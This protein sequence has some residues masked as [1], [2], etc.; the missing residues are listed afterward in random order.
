LL[1]DLKNQLL[2]I[3]LAMQ[4]INTFDGS[5]NFKHPYFGLLNLKQTVK[6]LEIHTF[7]HLK[8]VRDIKK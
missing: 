8:I 3:T 4:K 5:K 1:A 7:H 2:L 6:F